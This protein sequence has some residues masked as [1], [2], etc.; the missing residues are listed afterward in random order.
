[1][2]IVLNAAFALTLLLVSP[3]FAHH[4]PAV[5]D[6]DSVVAFQGKVSHFGWTNPHVYIYVETQDAD[7]QTV[8]WEIETSPTP[9]LTRSGWTRDS[10]A[11]GSEVAIRANPDKND[12]RKHALLISVSTEDS[13]TLIPRSNFLRRDSDP[14]TLSSSSDMSG[15]WE[16]SFSD[17]GGFY[18]SA[19]QVIPTESG[20]AVRD[21]YDREL[22]ISAAQC[23]PAS[24]PRALASVYLKE[25][26][27]HEDR[28]LLRNELYNLERTI[29]LDGREHPENSSRTN[30]GHSIGRWEDEVLIVDTT[31][32]EAH[33]YSTSLPGLPSGPDK[34]VI[35]RFALS[36]DGT[37]IVIDFALED[38]EYLEEPFVGKV[39]WYYA[40]HLEMLG[41]DC[42]P[43]ISRRFTVQ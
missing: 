9:I 10:L 29:Y 23:I 38:P 18:A 40:P 16:L 28:I 32:F 8:E 12:Q 24:T 6:Q 33:P 30:Q 34:H 42:D 39:V 15:V 3:A 41:F 26:E 43:E 22:D 37:R 4:S 13:E 5:F 7:G 21:R 2:R 36:E 1:M 31:L 35:E 14:E 19:D 11:I 17:F 20:A 27:I 25:I